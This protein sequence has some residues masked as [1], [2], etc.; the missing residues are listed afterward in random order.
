VPLSELSTF[1]AQGSKIKHTDL[2]S[3]KRPMPVNQQQ[4][5]AILSD[6]AKEVAEQERRRQE[7]R[8]RYFNDPDY[9][10]Y[11]DEFRRQNVGR[12]FISDRH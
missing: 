6:Y 1:L 11:I 5:D 10:A 7:F 2:S 4:C 9:R 8:D 3:N 12:W